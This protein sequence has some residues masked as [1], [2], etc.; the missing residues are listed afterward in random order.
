M[1]IQDVQG[2]H[3]EVVFVH[4]QEMQTFIFNSVEQEN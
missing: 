1:A 3:V 4:F 2:I